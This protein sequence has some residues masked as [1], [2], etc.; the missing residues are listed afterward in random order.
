M[1][2]ENKSGLHTFL[3]FYYFFKNVPVE[4]F[5]IITVIGNIYIFSMYQH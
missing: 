4:F 3:E 2:I 1:R 5:N